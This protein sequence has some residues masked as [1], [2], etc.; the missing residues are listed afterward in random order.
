MKRAFLYAALLI[1]YLLHNDLWL[2]NDGRLWRG[3]PAGM[4]YHIGL[5]L[6]VTLLMALFVRYAWPTEIDPE[7]R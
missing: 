3:L 1:L 6:A 7:G 4:L 5:C 2:W